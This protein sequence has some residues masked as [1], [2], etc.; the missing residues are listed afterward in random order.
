M[1]TFSTSC[2]WLSAQGATLSPLP[3]AL[4]KDEP[5]F[6]LL[7]PK[8]NSSA[9]LLSQVPFYLFRNPVLVQGSSSVIQQASS[10]L[11]LNMI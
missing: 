9:F 10:L 2:G 4:M 1:G 8:P 3:L 11:C 6:F 7:S 5:A